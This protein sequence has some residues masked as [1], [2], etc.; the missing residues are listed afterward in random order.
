MYIKAYDVFQESAPELLQKNVSVL[1]SLVKNMTEQS[2][3]R[4]L[5]IKNNKKG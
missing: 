1:Q 3:L 5:A 2:N 4:K